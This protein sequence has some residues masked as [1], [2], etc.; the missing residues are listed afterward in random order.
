MSSCDPSLSQR[1][2]YG[3]YSNLSTNLRPAGAE[4]K[5]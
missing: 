4:S 5:K 1:H 2:V 3:L